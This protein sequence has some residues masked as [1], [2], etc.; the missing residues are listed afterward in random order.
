[1]LVEDDTGDVELI[2]FLANVEW[3]KKRL[4]LGATRWV[5]GKLEMWDGHLQMVHPDRVMDDRRSCGD[6]ARRAGQR[7]DRGA[8]SA[9]RSRRRAQ[10]GLAR[11]G[12]ADGS[13]SDVR[14]QALAFAGAL[15]SGVHDPLTPGDIERPARPRRGSPMT[16]CSPTSSRCCWCA[17]ACAPAGRAHAGD[18]R[19]PAD[20]RAALPF[21]LTGAQNRR[22]R[23]RSAPI[24]P[25][26]KRMIRLLQGDVGS[27][28]TVVALLAMAHVVEAGR[29]A[30]L[31]A[32][33]EILARQHLERCSR[34]A[35]AGFGSRC[36][37]AAIR[38]RA[39][40]AQ[41]AALAAGEIDIVVGTHALFQEASLPRPR[42]CR[43]RRAASLRRASAPRAG[44][45]GRGADLLVMTATPIPRTWC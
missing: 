14:G 11:R 25:R 35:A 10:A 36:S 34:S 8:L 4:P 40:R 9:H 38:R 41:L 31:M 21:S 19:S 20:A 26:R 24:S 17:R 15:P 28:K 45:Q 42:P 1:M 18:G 29:Q 43:G 23:A 2:F 44:E 13:T 22:A 12:P 39:R 33:T 16:S 5:S 7:P 37:P 32:P 3:I 6:A 30:A 27:G